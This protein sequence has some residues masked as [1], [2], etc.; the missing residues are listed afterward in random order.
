MFDNTNPYTLR[1][2]IVGGI[3]HYLISFKDGQNIRHETEVSRNVYQEFLRFIRIERSLRHWDERH[4]EHSE[5]TDGTL[6]RRAF[7]PPKSLEEA[8]VDNL[9]NDR[10]SQAINELTIKQRRRF[11]LYFEFGLTYEQI[12]DVENCTKRAIK[13]SVDCAKERIAKKIRNY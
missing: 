3:A 12:A 2:E 4:R 6:S 9:R 7:S 8:V 5:V 10:L 1:R 11:I 13:F